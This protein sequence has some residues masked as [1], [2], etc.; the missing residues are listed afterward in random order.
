MTVMVIVKKLIHSSRWW[1]FAI[2]LAVLLPLSAYFLRQNNLKMLELRDAV[3]AVDQKSGN[4]KKIDPLLSELRDYVLSHMNA[5][6]PSPLELPGSFNVAVEQARKKAEKS[7]NANSSIYKKAQD[8]CERPELPLTVRAEC[9]QNY[10]TVHGKP[11]SDVKVLDIPPKEQF[12]YSFLSPTW[13]FDL[14]GVF[15]LL[16]ALT[17]MAM[18]IKLCT[19]VIFPRITGYII[20]Q[21]LE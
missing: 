3:V 11:G 21:P 2:A 7:G 4:I 16:S 12:V 6:L 17:T 15:V 18:L 13:S 9:M 10:I 14:A 1:H 8:E 5:S 19:G 20:K